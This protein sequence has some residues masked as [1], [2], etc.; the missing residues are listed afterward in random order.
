MLYIYSVQRVALPCN[1]KMLI[2]TATVA[3]CVRGRGD[4]LS[5]EDGSSAFLAERVLLP[6]TDWAPDH[7]N[8][9]RA[10][11]ARLAGTRPRK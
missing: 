6:L 2:P 11:A 10:I 7:A 3:S 8:E 5:A 1:V 9:L 4:P